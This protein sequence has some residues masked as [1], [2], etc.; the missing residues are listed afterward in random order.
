MIGLETCFALA[1]TALKDKVELAKIIDAIANNPRV[2]LGLK[3]NIEEGNEADLTLFDPKMKWTFSESKFL[4]LCEGVS[5][6]QTQ[7]R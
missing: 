5:N 6:Y 3:N 1:N 2:I 4:E 7:K